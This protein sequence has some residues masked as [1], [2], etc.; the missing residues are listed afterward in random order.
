MVNKIDL[1]Y[2]RENFAPNIIATFGW[3]PVYHDF[4]DGLTKDNKTS[5]ALLLRVFREGVHPRHPDSLTRIAEHALISANDQCDSGNKLLTDAEPV[6]IY[7]PA[8]M[9]DRGGRIYHL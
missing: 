8:L 5:G 3:T 7:Q 2:V 1:A 6:A 4:A 9:N